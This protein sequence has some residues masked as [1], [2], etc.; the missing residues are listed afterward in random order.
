MS[1]DKKISEEE[2]KKAAGGSHPVRASEVPSERP[3]L[4]VDDLNRVAGGVDDAASASEK[5]DST[6]LGKGDLQRVTGASTSATTTGGTAAAGPGFRPTLEG[7]IVD[8]GDGGGG[9]A[10]RV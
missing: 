10:S 6:A 9:G 2:M 3:V 5:P 4:E 1:D 7:D 8:A